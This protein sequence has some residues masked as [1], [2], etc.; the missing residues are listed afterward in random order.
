MRQLALPMEGAARTRRPTSPRFP[1]MVQRESSRAPRAL[2]PVAAISQAPCTYDRVNRAAGTSS[3][4]TPAHDGTWMR[5]PAC[6]PMRPRAYARCDVNV[7]RDDMAREGPA[8]RLQASS[9]TNPRTASNSED[10][11]APILPEYHHNRQ[12]RV[13]ARRCNTQGETPV[14]PCPFAA[15]RVGHARKPETAASLIMHVFRTR[16]M[17]GTTRSGNTQLV[18]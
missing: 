9:R 7:L 17:Y 3:R 8:R 1:A 5:P 13:L 11:R 18:Y 16:S 14:S 15:E 10:T 12:P 4:Q 6:A 2:A